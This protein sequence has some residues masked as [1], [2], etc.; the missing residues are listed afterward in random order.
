MNADVL[1]AFLLF[2]K[3]NQKG[4]FHRSQTGWLSGSM[5]TKKTTQTNN[6]NLVQD[7][8]PGLNAR[9]NVMISIECSRTGHAMFTSYK[10]TK[11]KALDIILIGYS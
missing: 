3:A 4:N 9:N 1:L 6:P 10:E 8:C 11:D 7:R 5:K 2:R